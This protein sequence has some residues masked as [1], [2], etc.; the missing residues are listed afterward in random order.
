MSASN[1]VLDKTRPQDGGQSGITSPI[2]SLPAMPLVPGG[3]QNY[4][5]RMATTQSLM[6]VGNGNLSGGGRGYRMKRKMTYRRHINHIIKVM[7]GCNN[8]KTLKHRYR[9]SKNKNNNKR[10][11][12]G[13]NNITP[14]ITGG[15]IEIPIP[16][17]ASADQINTLK[18]LS[19]GLFAGQT[20]EA[21]KPPPALSPVASKFSGGGMTRRKIMNQRRLRYKKSIGRKCRSRRH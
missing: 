7:K 6:Q 21:N 9:H 14:A 8:K 11:F 20:L 18:T 1:F 17:G 12:R 16:V 13:G 19:G 15:K 4:A 3:E 2:L 10:I 5:N